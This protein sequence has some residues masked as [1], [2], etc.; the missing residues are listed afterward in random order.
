MLN[1]YRRRL[2]RPVSI[3][4]RAA[5]LLA[6]TAVFGC[7]D[8]AEPAAT[9]DSI[10][11][12]AP[13]AQLNG[14]A[15]P[16]HYSLALTVLPEKD[17]FDGEVTIDVTLSERVEGLYLHG[18]NLNVT[19]AGV[20]LASGASVRA[21]YRQLTE[22]GIAYVAF[23]RPVDAQDIALEF[24]YDAPFD[25]QLLGL[26][27]VDEDGRSYAFTQFESIFARKAFVSFDEPEHKTP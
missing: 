3:P 9:S 14:P 23:G 16:T 20:R 13:R 2:A 6:L 1:E 21:S 25:R 19:R 15:V 8:A 5:A 26:Y 11:T 24:T 4:V 12:N 17:R 7:A 10:A 27:R 18:N 22:D